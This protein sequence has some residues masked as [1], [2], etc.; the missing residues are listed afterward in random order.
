[1]V[2]TKKMMHPRVVRR[3]GKYSKETGYFDPKTCSQCIVVQLPIH[4]LWVVCTN[5]GRD[6]RS[7]WAKRS[8]TEP[9]FHSYTLTVLFV[10][11]HKGFVWLLCSGE[12]VLVLKNRR[13]R[14]SKTGNAY[15]RTTR[16]GRRVEGARSYLVGSKLHSG[17]AFDQSCINLHDDRLYGIGTAPALKS[18]RQTLNLAFNHRWQQ[19]PTRYLFCEKLHAQGPSPKYVTEE[20]KKSS[21][22]WW[23]LWF[24]L[25]TRN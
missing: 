20:E 17:F 4:P 14:H 24:Y 6:Q 22:P 12:I 5:L 8:Q 1:M 11:L 19:K 25:Q 16:R 13:W 23:Q 10:N 15:A 9:Q 3:R 7:L 21:P 2:P 18:S